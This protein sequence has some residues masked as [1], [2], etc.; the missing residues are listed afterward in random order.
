MAMLLALCNLLCGDLVGDGQPYIWSYW[1]RPRD[2]VQ[3][4]LM[5]LGREL[6]A[7]AAVHLLQLQA[8]A[9]GR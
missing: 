5:L 6:Q 1:Y 4:H 8:V 9:H 7:G 2:E 3:A